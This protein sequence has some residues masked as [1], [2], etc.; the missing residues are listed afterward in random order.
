MPNS[1]PSALREEEE[2]YVL[3]C[4]AHPE[5]DI[6]VQFEIDSERVTA[7]QEAQAEILELGP[8]SPAGGRL[9]ACY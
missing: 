4:Q 6:E 3:L 5:T 2:G 7:P 9:S 8:A 1:V